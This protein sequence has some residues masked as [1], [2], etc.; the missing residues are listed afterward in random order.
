M[1]E[2]ARRFVRLWSALDP[3]EQEA[4]YD[5]LVHRVDC[6]PRHEDF[7]TKRYRSVR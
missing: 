4:I 5:L 1:T 6:G 7:D 3:I 2:N